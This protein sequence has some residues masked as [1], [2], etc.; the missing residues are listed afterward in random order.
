MKLLLDEM[1]SAAIAEQLRRH[2]HDAIAV[3]DRPDLRGQADTVIFSAAQA[4]QRLIVTE[5]VADFRVIAS[6]ELQHG[7]PY[8][9]LIFT[10]NRR[11]SRHDP[12]TPGRLVD[13]LGRLLNGESMGTNLEHWL[14]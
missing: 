14:T 12:R 10:T 2:G 6:N 1:W 13:A 11:Y 4:E 8:A 3:Q 9:G 5:N 7:R